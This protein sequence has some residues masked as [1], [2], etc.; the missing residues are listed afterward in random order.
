M[1]ILKEQKQKE[2]SK[3]QKSAKGP[4]EVKVMAL[5]K[6]IGYI[7]DVITGQRKYGSPSLYSIKSE[8]PERLW[9]FIL[10]TEE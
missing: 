8:D 10:K 3:V 6:R 5:L 1:L 7:L 9:L 2:E 4:D